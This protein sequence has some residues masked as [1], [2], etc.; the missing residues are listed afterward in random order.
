MAKAD[1]NLRPFLNDLER[2]VDDLKHRLPCCP[3][4][5]HWDSGAEVCKVTNPRIRPPAPVIAFGCWAF[6]QDVPF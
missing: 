6:D 2:I 4:C 1:P 3:N 5:V